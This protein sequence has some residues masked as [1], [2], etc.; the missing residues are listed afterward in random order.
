M[1]SVTLAANGPVQDVRPRALGVV[2]RPS[3]PFRPRGH[4]GRAVSRT[5]APPGPPRPRGERSPDHAPAG[6]PSTRPVGSRA[7][8][9]IPSAIIDF[10]NS[11][12]GHGRAPGPAFL[13]K[14]AVGAP[15]RDSGRLRCMRPPRP[16]VAPI[17][18]FHAVVFRFASIGGVVCRH[19]LTP[20]SP[21]TVHFTKSRPH[22]ARSP[23][24]PA[25][26]PPTARAE[27]PGGQL[28]NRRSRTA[29]QRSAT[30]PYATAA[31][32]LSPSRSAP[33]PSATSAADRSSA[34][35]SAG[36]ACTRPP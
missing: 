26:G 25:R 7:C 2:S 29:R 12:P 20:D 36:T 17:R 13:A 14:E 24:A 34:S 22:T 10:L 35:R 32:S 30:R 1:P 23:R 5:P 4:V 31:R 9:R 33:R 27:A 19:M 3:R 11:P 6:A 16:N 28:A 8:S 18:T 15:W 21:F